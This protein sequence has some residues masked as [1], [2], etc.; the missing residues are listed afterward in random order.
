MADDGTLTP[1]SPMRMA[2]S[3]GRA[4]PVPKL[5]VSFL[6]LVRVSFNY[7]MTEKDSVEKELQGEDRARPGG[8]DAGETGARSENDALFRVRPE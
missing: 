4:A 7:D 2:S 3:H 5:K 1:A 6:L 8:G